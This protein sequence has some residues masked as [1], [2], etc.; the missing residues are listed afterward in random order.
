MRMLAIF[1]TI[2]FFLPLGTG[3]AFPHVTS[4][5]DDN[6]TIR[7]LLKARSLSKAPRLKL[8]T[9]SKS[10]QLTVDGCKKTHKCHEIDLAIRDKKL[11]FKTPKGY[12]PL[13]GPSAEITSTRGRLELD[14]DTYE[15]SLRLV[16]DKKKDQLLVINCLPLHDYLS[17][18]LFRETYQSWPRRTH[19]TQAI[20]SRSYA[21]HHVQRARK[22]NKPYDIANYN[23]H[24]TY[25]GCH[26]YPHLDDAITGT[27]NIVLAHKGDVALTMF[28]ACC[29]G[30]IPS[31]MDRKD[32]KELPYLAR[33]RRCRF[34]KNYT[35]F[36]WKRTFGLKELE[37]L[38]NKTPE[39]KIESRKIGKLTNVKVRK[40]DPAGLVLSIELWGSK[41]VQILKGKH[42]FEAVRS[43][44]KSRSYSIH[45]T[46]GSG[47]KKGIEFTFDGN[48]FG[49]QI[50]LCQ[51]GSHEMVKSGWK[52][53]QILKFYYPHTRLARLQA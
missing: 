33:T 35:L 29:G 24:Q 14:G 51:R 2:A 41:G 21:V 13:V 32:I 39:T 36:S 26:G 45:K 4:P 5:I 52:V 20:V 50:G 12:R 53:S 40:K 23:C 1:A 8:S 42:F 15:G 9:Q 46:G 27:R 16:V 19:E 34:C 18:V 6:G 7:V 30:A 28:D 47:S 48:G 49:H 37:T 10:L 44:I 38:L 25:R 17:A 22:R 3:L 43:K 11:C 31:K